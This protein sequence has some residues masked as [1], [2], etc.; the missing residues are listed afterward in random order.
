[1]K[2]I[3]H[4][5][6]DGTQRINGVGTHAIVTPIDHPGARVSNT[7]LILTSRVVRVG[8]WGEFETQNTIYRPDRPIHD[9]G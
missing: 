4:Y 7:K 9:D 8:S 5:R 3:V 6:N 1:M 2:P